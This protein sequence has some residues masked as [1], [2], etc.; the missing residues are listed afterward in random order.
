MNG[1]LT[2]ILKIFGFYRYCPICKTPSKKFLQYG[3]HPREDAQC[4]KC[5]SLERHR[6]M[7]LYLMNETELFSN[8]M[9]L[10]HFSPENCLKNVFERQKNIEYVTADLEREDVDFK[11]DMTKLPF[12]SD[13]YDAIICIHVLEHIE[14]DKTALKE[15][16]RILRPGGWALI[17][18]PMKTGKTFED[19]SI[20][21]PE[22]RLKSFGQADHVRLYGEDFGEI[23]FKSGFRVKRLAYAEKF[24][25]REVDYYR[26][27]PDDRKTEYFY[28]CFK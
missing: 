1:I 17:Q 22:A 4:P 28:Q 3:A 5:G 19:P 16:L 25:D 6:L 20:T 15:L 12:K 23:L 18:V 8:K 26:L 2:G 11:A 24:N 9:K 14:D 13:T 21:T 10:I 27:L 7:Y